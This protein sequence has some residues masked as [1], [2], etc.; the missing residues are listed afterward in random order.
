MA[1]RDILRLDDFLR[2]IW[3]DRAELERHANFSRRSH[4]RNKRDIMRID[5]QERF[6][7]GVMVKMK[8]RAENVLLQRL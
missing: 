6:A 5:Y 1:V 8:W 4:Y 2:W 7:R 3:N